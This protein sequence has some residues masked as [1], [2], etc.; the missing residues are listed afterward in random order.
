MERYSKKS[1]LTLVHTLR[2]LLVLGKGEKRQKHHWISALFEIHSTI[3][4]FGNANPFC[5]TQ[6]E[7]EPVEH[8]E[9][10]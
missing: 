4:A 5:Q 2:V 8:Q 1:L 10:H 9:S 6:H 7:G 3:P